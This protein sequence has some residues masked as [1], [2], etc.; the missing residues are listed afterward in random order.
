MYTKKYPTADVHRMR[1]LL[2]SISMVLSLSLVI[3]A[4]EW[5]VKVESRQLTGISDFIPAEEILNVP[6]TEHTPPPPKPVQPRIHEVPDEEKVLEEV[7]INLD[8]E[9]L[10]ETPQVQEPIAPVVIEEEAPTDEIFLIVEAPPSFTGGEE[11]LIRFVVKNLKYP[12]QAR[13]MGIEGRVFVKCIIEKDGAVTNAHVIKGIGGGCDE[14]A[15]RVIS[16]L[17]KFNPGKQRGHAVRVSMV[18]PIVFRI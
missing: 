14:E 16:L 8:N 15:V 13:R 9:T 10:A 4:F 2:F 12:S 1:P 6:P 11:A 3:M 17:P 5:N 7:T 18:F